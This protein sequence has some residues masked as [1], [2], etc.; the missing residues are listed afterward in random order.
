[1]PLIDTF[2]EIKKNLDVLE[3]Y[4]NFCYYNDKVKRNPYYMGIVL[5]TTL[6]YNTKY[7]PYTF[8]NFY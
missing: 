3:N 7:N 4:N 2:I 6:T 8:R 1:M 5:I